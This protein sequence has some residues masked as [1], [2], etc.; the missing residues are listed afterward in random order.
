MANKTSC[1]KH[2]Q[3]RGAISGYAKV[4]QVLLELADALAQIA[5]NNDVKGAPAEES[6]AHESEVANGDTKRS[7]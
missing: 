3:D 6:A 4:D 1:T 2:G 5:P 7:A